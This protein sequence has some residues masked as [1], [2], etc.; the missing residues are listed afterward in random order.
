MRIG[1]RTRGGH[2]DDPFADLDLGSDAF[3][4]IAVARDRVQAAAVLVAQEQQGVF[5]AEQIGEPA[6][7]GA[8]ERVEIRAAP[9]AFAQL[10][11]RQRG[12]SPSRERPPSSRGDGRMSSISM[13]R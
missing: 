5:V 7:R 9:E 4:V 12:G 3:G 10:Q 1:S 11:Q 6:E 8:D 2:A 13:T